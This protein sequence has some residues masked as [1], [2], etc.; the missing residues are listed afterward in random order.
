LKQKNSHAATTNSGV[1]TTAS[2]SDGSIMECFG[3]IQN[4]VELKFEDSKDLR[5]V[6]FYCDWFNNKLGS[7][8]KHNKKLGLVEV[9]HKLRVS[10]YNPFVLA[11]QVELVY[12][13]LYPCRLE[14]S[15]P[16]WIVQKVYPPGR[17]PIPEDEG[18]DECELDRTV[19]EAYQ[20]D[21]CNGPFEVDIGMALDKLDS[22]T[23]DIIVSKVCKKKRPRRATKVLLT[24]YETRHGTSH[25][26]TITEEDD[27]EDF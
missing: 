5:V 16:W 2:A 12:Y 25:G 23:G 20:E 14:S 8:V 7:R 22:D 19:P 26:D 11:H 9:N 6:F 27:T 18:Y 10:G 15:E 24:T 1:V 3:V 17:L 13:M 4:I 21:E